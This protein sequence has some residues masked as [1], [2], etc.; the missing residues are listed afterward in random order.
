MKKS[1]NLFSMILCIVL[2]N[3]IGCKKSTDSGSTDSGPTVTDFD[4][5]VYHLVTVGSQVWTLE[6][7]RV[8]H[9]RNGDPIQQG[10]LEYLK[11]TDT[12]GTFWAYENNLGYIPD[13]GLL[14]NFYAAND[15]R[16]IAPPGFHIPS[17]AEYGGLV[18]SLG[19]DYFAVPWGDT[20]TGGKLKEAGND[21]WGIPGD[22]RTNVGATNSSH[23]TGRPGG[24]LYL[25]MFVDLRGYGAWWT[26][27]SLTG[28]QKDEAL[29]LVLAG[30]NK[31]AS[32]GSNFKA[33][34]LSERCIKDNPTLK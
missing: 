19:G 7:L 31:N 12:T 26:T 20:I 33:S 23:W 25:G 11:T 18:N 24:I 4:G 2:M 17:D 30:I 5:N 1:V 28:V 13:Y 29:E 21:H 22:P 6:N 9:Y 32:Q 15:P 3:S 27:T 14:Y 10:S 8:R 34:G 16:S